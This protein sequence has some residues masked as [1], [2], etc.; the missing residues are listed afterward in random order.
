VRRATLLALAGGAVAAAGIAGCGALAVRRGF[1]A[2]DEPGAA[3]A[4]LA[5]TVRRWAVPAELREA[6]NPLPATPEVLAEARAHWADHCASCH[7][8]DGKGETTL[9]RRMYPR[10]PDMTLPRTQELSDGELFA[11]IE[12]GIRLTGM[13]G[14]G[15]GTAE[16]ARGSWELVRLVRHLP[17]L[18]AEEIAEMEALNP[19]PRREWEETRA[20][21]EFLR[22]GD[23]PTAAATPAGDAAGHHH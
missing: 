7:G 23:P 17:R 13:P 19:R 11:V 14:W 1:S 10:A 18:T 12:N 2:L 15:E 16:S 20:E 21:E 22:G 6:R 3:E 5:R 8:N 9:G 4:A